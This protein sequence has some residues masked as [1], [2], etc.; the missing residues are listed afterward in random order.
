MRR[1]ATAVGILLLAAQVARGEAAAGAL[2][3]DY[4]PQA[5]FQFGGPVGQR[6]AANRSG[7]LL[8]T[9]QA[10]PGLL[11]MFA[12]RDRQPAPQLVPWA[13]E[14]VGKYLISAIQALRMNDD[15]QLEQ[16]VQAVVQ[17][18]IA[19]QAEDGYL[20]PFPK[21][22]RLLG[23]WD[24]WGHYHV[25]LAL[26]MW[27]ERTGDPA[28]LEA[29][30]KAADLI[31]KTYL[32][33]GRRPREAGWSEMNLAV[34][35]T[36]G[37]LY[38]L[39]GQERYLKQMRE[40]EKDWELEGDYFRTGLAGVEYYRT[41]KP[42]WES[43]HDV[44]GLVE[45]YRIT[46]DDRYRTAFLHHWNSIRCW[47]RRNTGGFTSGEQATGTPYE[48]TPIETCCTIAWMAITVD[49]LRLTAD[50]RAADELELSTYNGALGAQS[51]SGSW[52]TYN[53]PINGIREASHH[54]IVF[55]ARA[56]APDL[57][58]CSVNG[59][60]G[61]G[62]LSE[63]ALMQGGSGLAVNY[64][65]PM[66]ASVHLANGMV[67]AVSEETRYPLDG[68][69]KLRIEPDKAAEFPLWVRIPAWAA[70]C[71][72]EAPG[73]QVGPQRPGSYCEIRGLWKPGDEVS[74]TLEMPLR[75]EAGD[76]EM[77]GHMAV[78]RGPILLAYDQLWNDFDEAELPT[79]TPELLK[80]AK[81][82]FPNPKDLP[83]AA[84][85]FA[86]WLLVDIPVEGRTLRLC[87][88]ANA[89]SR[90]SRYDSWLPAKN[91][92]PS[93]PVADLPADGAT[94]PA[95]RMLFSW[96]VLA[97]ANVDEMHK[98]LIAET[99][100]LAKPVLTLDA[101]RGPRLVVS[102]EQ[103]ARLKPGVDYY[104]QVVATNA[105]GSTASL[106][107]AKRF[108]IDPKLPPLG[109]ADL[110][111]Y[112]ERADGVLVEASLAGDAKPQY[113]TLLEARGCQPAAGPDGTPNT[114]VAV[115]GQSGLLRYQLRRFP[116]ESYTVSFWF[117]HNATEPHLGQLFSAWCHGMDDPLRICIDGGKLSTRLEGSGQML[118]TAAVAIERDRWYFVT[119]VKS[120]NTLT[121]YLDGK[122]VAT[123]PTPL[124]VTSQANDFA[125]G[126]N[127]HFTGSSEFLACRLAKLVF[128]V[129]ALSAEEVATLY[130]QQKK[131]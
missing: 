124:S 48:V 50:S 25:M 20:G 63:W 109:D 78:Y 13:G 95:G 47:D 44:Q 118:S 26:L 82:T 24:L 11:G 79:L 41:P 112:G 8:R 114:A 22:K 4:D 85:R 40:I 103:A 116:R 59:P 108:C 99:P 15:P 120:R 101:G 117:A 6:V 19:S 28:A 106:L 46:G 76:G 111:E 113:G 71:S 105:V 61:L 94:V 65:G 2:R 18:L 29:T 87:D 43:L 83:E 93:R 57:N 14:F 31:C 1:A 126:G 58:C 72:L 86:P 9:P 73:K 56:G 81:V 102:A 74:L 37:R 53:T 3:A 122:A 127:P 110:T 62:M 70:G 17:E 27:H 130:A 96:R 7:W 52:C 12:L 80:Q 123:M 97:A 66:K 121:L 39:T 21:A 60:R 98:L 107:P 10:D 35:H 54:T 45:L 84:G 5:H 115:D 33:T 104:W 64:Y 68:Q 91:L 75:Y 88:F 34:I 38:R 128:R 16:T 125:L 36:L 49:A 51:P 69:V 77:A 32:D 30:R 67:V 90:G 129:Q 55:Q 92:L 100:D 42:R 119:A 23:E 131:P 89:G